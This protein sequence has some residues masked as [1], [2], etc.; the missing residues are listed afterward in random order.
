VADNVADHSVTTKLSKMKACSAH[1][2]QQ[3]AFEH[4]IGVRGNYNFVFMGAFGPQV[5]LDEPAQRKGI[6]VKIQTAI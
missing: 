5:P 3:A 2:S 6:H 4:S 1:P